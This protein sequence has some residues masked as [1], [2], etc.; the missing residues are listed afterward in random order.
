M[1]IAYTREYD[2]ILDD[3][4]RALTTVPRFYEA[5]EMET[6][7]WEGLSKDEREICI[8][9]L[10]DDLFYVLGTESSTDVGLG[11]AVYD[12]GHA[13]I[14]ITANE[15]LVHVISLRE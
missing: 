13:V 3:L 10:A 7:D 15:Q 8:R 5:F 14:K 4:S 9:T 1:A 11:N 6:D 12:P 2:Q